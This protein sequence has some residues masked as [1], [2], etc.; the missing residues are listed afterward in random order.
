MTKALSSAFHLA[1]AAIFFGVV[2]SHV[3]GDPGR[4][5]KQ[6]GVATKRSQTWKPSKALGRTR[7]DIEKSTTKSLVTDAGKNRISIDTSAKGGRAVW[8]LDFNP[9]NGRVQIV[10]VKH[11]DEMSQKELEAFIKAQVQDAD[12]NDVE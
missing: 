7:A 2:A 4:P 3:Q 9:V 1:A 6:Q 8:Y 11:P 10:T 12:L 5:T